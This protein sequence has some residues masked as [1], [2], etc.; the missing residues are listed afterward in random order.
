MRTCIVGFDHNLLYNMMVH[1]LETILN[2]TMIWCGSFTLP[3]PVW[4]YYQ[5]HFV[6]AFLSGNSGVRWSGNETV[7]YGNETVKWSGNETVGCGNE[8][9]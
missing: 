7:G 2:K 4:I 9:V 8:T 6:V 1:V 5:V 3:V